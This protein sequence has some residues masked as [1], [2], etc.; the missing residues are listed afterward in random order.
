VT[1]RFPLYT[2]ADIHGP[3]VEG[4][5]RRGWDVARAVDHYPEGVDDQVHFERAA[6][7]GR[8]LASNDLDQIL[9]AEGWLAASRSFRGLITWH[10]TDERWLSV[11]A[12]LDAFDAIAGEEDP[13][14]SYPI[15]RIRPASRPG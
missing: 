5:M 15:V 1:G 8:V 7:E 4:L 13:F 6:R 12:L 9:I 14:S 2:D 10:K 3:L 11:G